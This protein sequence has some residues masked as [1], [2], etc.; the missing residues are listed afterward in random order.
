MAVHASAFVHPDAQVHPSCEIGPHVVVD[1]PIQI[2]PDCRLGPSVVLLGHTEIGAG[3]MIHAHAVIGDVPQ[4]F[5][6][7]GGLSYCRVGDCCVIREG[8]TIHRAVTEKGATLVGD[9]CYLMTNSHVGHDCKL[10]VNVTLVSGALLGGYVEVGDHAIISGNAAV[11]QFVR[12]GERAMVSGLA[13][14]VQDVP[15]FLM[16]DRDGSIVGLNSIGLAR[17]NCTPDERREV[18]T[19]FKVVYRSGM[20]FQRALEMAHE[21]AATA[22]GRRF[23]QFL[24]TESRRGLR[25]STAR[26]RTTV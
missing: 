21:I 15:P 20:S 22:A 25:K 17:G 6:F 14:V 7:D 16:T 3:C 9:R 10:G 26:H 1:G 5:K 2:G 8:A 13:K 19:L 11:H 4:D 18:K 23:V 12:I 24:M